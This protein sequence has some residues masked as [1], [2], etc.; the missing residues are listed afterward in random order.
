[1]DDLKQELL[2]IQGKTIGIVYIF[3]QDPAPGYKHY[4]AWKSDVIS[5]WLMAIQELKCVPYIMDLRT[6]VYKVMN[7]TLPII[8]YV[9]NLNNGTMEL[10]TLGIVPSVCSFLSIPCIPCDTLSI[11]IGENKMISNLI[12]YAKKMN[13]PKDLDTTDTCGILRP[14]TLGSSYGIQ[15]GFKECSTCDCLY[16][17]FISG[18]D[19]TTPII[20]NPLSGKMEVLPA[21]MYYPKNQDVEWFLGQNEKEKH[22]GYDKRIVHIGEEAK[23]KYLELVKAFSIKTYCR[24]DARVQCKSFDEL[25]NMINH[26]IP[27]NDIYFLEINPTP[28]IKDNINFHTSL[29]NISADYEINKCIDEYKN[30]VDN[31]SYTGFILF[32]SISALIKA[33]REK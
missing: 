32:C 20:Y 24:I 33:K 8:D 18:F 6:F 5:S 22:Q 23:K 14:Y 11:M 16:Q 2:Q 19:M 21:V 30:I 27:L 28:T 15:R 1:M 17:E 9:V 10:S 7:N 4:E 31:Y 13:I 29:E 25:K 3:E 26:P 12:A